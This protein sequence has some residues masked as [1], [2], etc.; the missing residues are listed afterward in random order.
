MNIGRL[1]HR[2]TIQQQYNRPNGYGATV[3]D[4][5]DLHHVWAEVK[6]LSGREN[7][8]AAQIQPEATVHIWLRY[9]PNVDTTM[10]LRFND[11]LYL[12]IGV[13]NYKELN[14]SL[15]LQ[16]KEVANDNQR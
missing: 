11:K 12:I 4:W 15:L 9:L 14:R 1:R 10:R 16:C 8:S 3:S 13:V 7:F 6:P 5:Q 2:I